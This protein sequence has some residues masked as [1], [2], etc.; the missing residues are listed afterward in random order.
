[1]KKRS[2]FVSNSSSSSF[3]VLDREPPSTIS[4]CLLNKE[5]AERV[6]RH[7]LADEYDIKNKPKMIAKV[8][9]IDPA[10]RKIYLTQFISDSGEYTDPLQKGKYEYYEYYNGGHG[11]PYDEEA[12]VEIESG[13]MYDS[14]WVHKDHIIDKDHPLGQLELKFLKKEEDWE[15]EEDYDDDVDY[16]DLW[17]PDPDN[18]PGH[19]D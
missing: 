9:K 19:R 6:L 7:I 15:D 2:G 10:K 11:G 16:E 13:C 3:I 12:F 18:P 17:G 14:V 5:T 8:K 1:M 4:S